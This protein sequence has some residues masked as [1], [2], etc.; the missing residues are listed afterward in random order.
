MAFRTGDRVH[1]SVYGQGDIIDR[2]A[3]YITIAFDDG[4]TRKFVATRVHLKA[5]TAPRP[6]QSKRQPR[7]RRPRATAQI[8]PVCT[9]LRPTILLWR[10]DND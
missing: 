2:N 7:P 6:S 3:D 4:S 10:D 5:S 1:Q 8:H 9:G